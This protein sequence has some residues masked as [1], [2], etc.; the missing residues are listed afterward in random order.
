MKALA[1]RNGLGQHAAVLPPGT[2]ARQE[3]VSYWYELIYVMAIGANKYSILFF[4]RRLFPG[5]RLLV[6]LQTVGSIVFIWQI[7]IESAFIWQCNP[8]RKAWDVTVPGTCIKVIRLWLGNAIPNIVTDFFIITIPL[9]LVWKLQV[10]LS[11]RIALCG[12]FLT[13]FLYVSIQLPRWSCN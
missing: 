6:L 5:K 4:Y 13:G 7:A 3:K 2:I 1:Y 10:S 9:P 8:V 12:V 11:Q